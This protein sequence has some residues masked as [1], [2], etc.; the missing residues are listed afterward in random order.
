MLKSLDSLVR[1]RALL[2]A[3]TTREV[4]A[5]YRGSVLGFLW[6]FLNP[7]LLLAVY[8]FVFAHIFAAREGMGPDPYAVFLFTGL[9]PWTWFQASLLEGS[10]SIVSGGALLKKV[11]FPAEVLP[12]VTVLANGVHFAASLPVLLLVL[13]ATQNP[14]TVHL[15]ALVPLVATQF[16]LATGLALAL[17]ALSV[18]FRDV[19]DM[20]A[21]A[22]TL[23]F[24]AT[25]I[26]YHWS[27]VP[28]RFH[29]IARLNPLAHLVRGYQNALFYHEWPSPRGLAFTAI[30][31]VVTAIAGYAFFDRL[32]ETFPEEV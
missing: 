22:L 20:L 14:P 19:R 24:F 29:A 26:I 10:G 27:M 16:L 11:V 1:H 5:R 31:A 4:R 30:L 23:A 28:E 3:L 21:H 18:L 8:S 9:L 2:F 15:F 7:L 6:S 12:L 13:I 17:S 25:P 32:R